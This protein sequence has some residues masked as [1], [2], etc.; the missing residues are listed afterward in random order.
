AAG[1]ITNVLEKTSHN[2]SGAKSP[3]DFSHGFSRRTFAKDFRSTVAQ[4]ESVRPRHAISTERFFHNPDILIQRFGTVIG[5]PRNPGLYLE[6]LA[7]RTKSNATIPLK[8]DVFRQQGNAHTGS[9]NAEHRLNT[10][11]LLQA[12]RRGKAYDGKRR[13]HR[14]LPTGICAF[15]HTHKKNPL[16]V[17]QVN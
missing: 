1:H 15:G 5:P 16:D 9:D 3:K 14:V 13:V 11:S 7:Q 8:F 17:F 2:E 6:R 12:S 10:I 4:S